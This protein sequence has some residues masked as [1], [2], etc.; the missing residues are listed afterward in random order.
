MT[1]PP[2]PE[3]VT[4][5]AASESFYSRAL[6][7]MLRTMLV[8]SVLLLFPVFWF[9]G[10][11]GAI[12]VAA[13]SAVSY[14]NF[15]ALARGVEALADRIVNQH[16]QEKGRAIVLR[17]LVRYGLVGIVAYAIFESSA[18]AFRGF[19]W[20]LCLPVAA[21]MV[22]AGFEAYVAFRGPADGQRPT[23]KS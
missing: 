9:Y 1:N 7:R 4:E 23:A 5:N 15:R 18:L 16:S 17:F 21:M 12:G 2:N 3:A 10:W 13:G 11:V 14:I 22:E 19:L 20:G 8:V 6:P